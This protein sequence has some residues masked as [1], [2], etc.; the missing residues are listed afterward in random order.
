[1]CRLIIFLSIS[2]SVLT[3]NAQQRFTID[4]GEIWFAS[5][6]ELEIIKANSEK[7]QGLLDDSNKFAFFVEIQSF[8]GFNSQLQKEHFNERYLESDRF[9]K[10]TFVGKIIEEVD[11]TKAGVYEVR[12]KGELEIHGIK[13]TRI[14]KSKITVLGDKIS[15]DSK[16]VVPLTDHNISIPQIVN[17]KIATE[18]EVTF[19]ATLIPK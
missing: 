9:P 4:K 18:I 17:R 19:T 5:K 11:L 3:L 12:A 10:A 6:A 13:Q 7:V 16:F 15:I 14:I 1:M 8:N 2:L